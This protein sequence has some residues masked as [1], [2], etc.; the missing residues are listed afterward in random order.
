MRIF[1]ICFGVFFVVG[2]WYLIFFWV[3]FLRWLMRKLI[4]FFVDVGLVFSI[5]LILLIKLYIVWLLFLLENFLIFCCF[6][7]NRNFGFF[8]FFIWVICN[9]RFCSF[10]FS[11]LMFFIVIVIFF[12]VVEIYVVNRLWNI[13]L[14][15][16]FVIECIEEVL[17]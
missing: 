2:W 9:F 6:G 13:L 16:L 15:M 14:V 11:F 3:G 8:F 17:W 7:L 5:W 4:F 12:F 1:R 10:F